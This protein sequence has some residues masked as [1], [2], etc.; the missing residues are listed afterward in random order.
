MK[1][2]PP[3]TVGELEAQGKRIWL[4][5]RDCCHEVEQFASV[6]GVPGHLS[7]PEVRKIVVCSKCGSR[8]IDVKGQLGQQP[9]AVTRANA[10]AADHNRTH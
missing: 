6:L 1:H 4:Y 10:R 5:C 8:K 9:L 7:C 3:P 2:L